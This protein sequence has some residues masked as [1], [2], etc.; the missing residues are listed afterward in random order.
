[1][2]TKTIKTALFALLVLSI[3]IPSAAM[4]YA[5]EV[6]PS[7]EQ[8]DNA[9]TQM[10]PYVLI[11]DEKYGKFD[12][13]EAKLNGVSNSD[14]KIAKQVLK[15]QNNMI[16][17]IHENSSEKMY[18]DDRDVV[19]LGEYKKSLQEGKK[20]NQDAQLLGVQFAY[21]EVCGGDSSNP[22]EE[23]DVVTTG[24][25][26]SKSA[27][28]NALPSSYH[29]VPYYAS[30]NYGDDYHDPKTLY[31]CTTDSF[32]YQS[33][34]QGS[35][36]DWEYSQQHSPGEPNPELLAYDFPVWWWGF[37]VVEWHINN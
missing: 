7:A 9:L 4:V 3:A 15:A 32:R 18:V 14:I 22:H 24:D 16:H 11:D 1:M 37:Y 21:A 36:S 28:I 10:E 34:V 17:R 29:K 12:I 23:P 26:S 35:G 19:G 5:K 25:Y 27:A 8:I 33:I 31:S 2:T 6:P 30:G 20:D 13:K